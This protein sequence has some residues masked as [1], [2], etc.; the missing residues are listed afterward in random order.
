MDEFP[1]VRAATR[2]R[3]V[4]RLLLTKEDKSFYEYSKTFRK[5]VEISPTF[6]NVIIDDQ[7]TEKYKS[8]FDI[9]DKNNFPMGAQGS[10]TWG[11]K[12]KVRITSKSS[13][14]KIDVNFDFT[15]KFIPPAD[16]TK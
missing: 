11:R 10:K 9:K 4:E 7:I 6:D 2:F 1:E 3:P 12:F 14:K 16:K 15:K 8:A 13:G 5:Y